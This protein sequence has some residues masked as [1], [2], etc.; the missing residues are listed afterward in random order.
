MVGFRLKVRLGTNRS[1]T[2]IMNHSLISRLDLVIRISNNSDVNFW[3]MTV[4]HLLKVNESR[5]DT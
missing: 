5:E 3:K 2:M 1:Q 4:G